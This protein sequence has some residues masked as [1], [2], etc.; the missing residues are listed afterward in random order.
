VLL[1][2][3]PKWH[4]Y[5]KNPVDGGIPTTV[6][7]KLPEGFTASA[8]Q[9]PVPRKFELE[10]GLVSYGYEDEVMLLATITPPAKIESSPVTVSG[11]AS[12]LVCQSVC[13][14][15][16]ANVGLSLPVGDAKPDQQ[17]LFKMW[18]NRLPVPIE[19]TQLPRPA[20]SQTTAGGN[21]SVLQMKIDWTGEVPTDIE[22]FPPGSQNLMFGKPKVETSGKTTTVTTAVTKLVG[23]KAD[24]APL[25]SV[26]SFKT[27]KGSAGV[28]MPVDL[29]NIAPAR[30]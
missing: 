1:K 4:L 9:Y 24:T 23:Q 15:G 27:L 13:I 25:E 12:W 17:E 21:E 8:I 29:D 19:L 30:K 3:E 6:E 14:A 20:W 18:T 22:W 26:L 7:L 2:I 11:E 10:G 5:W 28:S 16:S